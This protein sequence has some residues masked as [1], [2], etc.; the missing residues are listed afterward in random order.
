MKAIQIYETNLVA[1]FCKEYEE[2][3]N[4]FLLFE[5]ASANENANTKVLESLLKYN[6]QQFLNSFLERV[7]LPKKTGTG[8]ATIIDQKPAIGVKSGKQGFIDLFISYGA[9]NVVLENKLYGAG[10]TKKQLAR[11]I[12]T[13]N[14][15]DNADFEKWL[16]KPVL[17]V[18]THLVYLTA[19]GT[20]EPSTDSLPD[21]LKDKINYYPI[22]YNDDILPWLEEDVLPNI[23]YAKDGMMIAGLQQYIAFLKY[24]LADESS[25]VVD[26]FAKGLVGTDKEKYHELLNVANGLSNLTKDEPD[27]KSLCRQLEVRAESIFSDDIGGDWVLHFTPSFL[28]LYKKAWTALD[29]RKYSIPSFYLCGNSTE[30]FL[31]TGCISNFSAQVA[32]LSANPQINNSNIDYLNHGRTAVYS[33]GE[34]VKGIKCVDVNDKQARKTYFNEIIEAVKDV[35]TKMDVVVD[36]VTSNKGQSP[37]PQ[38]ILKTFAALLP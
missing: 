18:D 9:V 37:E 24:H 25:Q 4:G 11:Y 2:K 21:A 14:G 16:V 20:K 3:N 35:V 22:N 7:G 33:L 10:D 1:E 36:I 13:V 28:V 32:H 31:K 27:I 5:L 26:A 19:D 17:N 30:K 15:V 38:I 23:P 29:T 8:L 6:K 12:A 34:L